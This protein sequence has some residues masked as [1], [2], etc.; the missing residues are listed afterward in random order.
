M[1]RKIFKIYLL[2]LLSGLIFFGAKNALAQVSYTPQIQEIAGKTINFTNTTEPLA[3]YIKNIYNYGVGVAAIV[4]TVV[5]MIGGFQWVTS[6]GSGEKVGEAKAWISAALSGLVLIIFSY[7]L[8]SIVSPNLVNFKISV[9]AK[10][11]K[12]EKVDDDATAYLEFTRLKGGQEMVKNFDVYDAQLRKVANEFGVDCNLL[13]AMMYTESQGNPN[14]RS[15]RNA[16]G[17]MQVKP[18]TA[19][20]LGIKGNLYDPLVSLTAGAKYVKTLQSTACNNKKTTKSKS[21]FGNVC[22]VNNIK[23]VIAAYNGG[24]HGA[25]Q[26]G[27]CGRARWECP[28]ELSETKKYVNFVLTNLTNINVNGWGCR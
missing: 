21:G 28:G 3:E 22:N 25:N 18:D 16:Q 7:G 17:L 24:P 5:L 10:I 27:P 26:V 4:A 9:L 19:E 14:A 1:K 23:Y 11:F 6:G 13:K 2:V 20:W 12:I 8:L 15:K